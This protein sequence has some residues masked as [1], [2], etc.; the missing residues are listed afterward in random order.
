MSLAGDHAHAALAGLVGAVASAAIPSQWVDNSIKLAFAL[1]A[2]ILTAIG[3]KVG[4]DLY[5]TYRARKKAA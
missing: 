1:P 5:E 2:G 3:Y 4:T